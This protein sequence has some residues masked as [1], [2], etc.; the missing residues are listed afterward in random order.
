[1]GFPAMSVGSPG[2]IRLATDVCLVCALCLPC[3][4][5]CEDAA[6]LLSLIVAGN[7][8]CP[9]PRGGFGSDVITGPGSI[10]HVEGPRPDSDTRL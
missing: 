7:D 5:C 6:W 4:V 9:R 1:M 10:T 2:M 3:A 8:Y